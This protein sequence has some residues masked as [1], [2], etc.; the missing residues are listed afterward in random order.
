MTPTSTMRIV[1]PMAPAQVR[2]LLQAI[3]P[4]FC[5]ADID[6]AFGKALEPGAH[7]FRCRG[8]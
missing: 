8:R 4:T 2:F 3:D 7:R 6:G 1:E 5:V